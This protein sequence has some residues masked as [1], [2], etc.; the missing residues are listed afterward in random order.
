MLISEL[1]FVGLSYVTAGA[2]SLLPDY[3]GVF[4]RKK[5]TNDEQHQ[6][7]LSI[8][9]TTSCASSR[10]ETQPLSRHTCAGYWRTKAPLE[11][12][13][14]FIDRTSGF[15]HVATGFLSRK[16]TF[17]CGPERLRGWTCQN[18][19]FVCRHSEFFTSPIPAG[20]WGGWRT[21]VGTAGMWPSVD[22]APAAWWPLPPPGKA[23]AKQRGWCHG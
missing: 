4:V 17:A 8:M 20:R 7:L 15:S 9:A 6:S 14:S 2:K 11:V 13:D 18:A 1:V 21:K 12:G 16:E 5:T 10:G 23:G 19:D 22:R 3:L